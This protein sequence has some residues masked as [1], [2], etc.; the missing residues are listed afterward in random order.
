MPTA[1][2]M[3][4]A[5][6]RRPLPSGANSSTVA[7][8]FSAGVV[9]G[10]ST[11]ER[12]PTE[13]NRR[14]PSRENAM[15]RVQWPPPRS[16]PPPGSSATTV[17]AGAARRDVAVLVRQPHHR[18]GVGDVDPPRI[19]ARRIERDA[20]RLVE[21]LREHARPR[22]LAAGEQATDDAQLAG[23]ALDDERVAV[24]RDANQ[25]RTIQTVGV[26]ID[27][28]SGRRLRP[29]GLRPLDDLGRVVGRLRRARRGQIGGG[30]LDALSRTLAGVVGERARP[31][32]LRRG[33]LHGRLGSRLR[34]RIC[35]RRPAGAGGPRAEIH[36]HTHDEPALGQRN[37][38]HAPV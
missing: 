6:T 2:R 28:E 11:L 21:A 7:R 34:R 32:G 33:R 13:T 36:R 10:S 16:R 1:L 30:D 24:G 17:S 12:E 26:E 38:R 5:N 22:R 31:G 15:S 23:V 25:A 9:S 29:G 19:V 8:S 35:P 4:D 20:E 27:P 14:L 18:V 37:R 3:P